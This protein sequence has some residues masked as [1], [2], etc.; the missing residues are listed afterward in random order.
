MCIGQNDV[1]WVLADQTFPAPGPDCPNALFQSKLTGLPGITAH[2]TGNSLTK[3]GSFCLFLTVKPVKAV[4][5]LKETTLELTGFG[6]T[7][8]AFSAY[9]DWAMRGLRFWAALVSG[10]AGPAFARAGT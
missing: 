7:A 3:Y 8:P 10:R 9:L 2:R 4:I 6:P 1:K 5:C